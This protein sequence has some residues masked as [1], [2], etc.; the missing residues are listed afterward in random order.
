M[1][2]EELQAQINGSM[3]T[4][5]YAQF[6]NRVLN[7]SYSYGFFVTHNSLYIILICVCSGYPLAYVQHI[8]VQCSSSTS[9]LSCLLKA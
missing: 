3:I 6:R 8:I 1:E 7:L 9:R 5:F 2:L 4:R